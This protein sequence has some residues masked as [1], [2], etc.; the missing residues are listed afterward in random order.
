MKNSLCARVFR[1]T[2]DLL[3]ITLNVIKEPQ[4][5]LPINYKDLFEKYLKKGNIFYA[6]F[7]YENSNSLKII[8]VVII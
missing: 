1:I 7:V 5:I 2:S 3:K 4:K 6:Y 8:L